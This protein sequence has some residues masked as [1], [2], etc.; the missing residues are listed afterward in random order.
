MRRRAPMLGW[1][2]ALTSLLLL[3]IV[4]AALWISI[5]RVV[6]APGHLEGGTLTLRAPLAGKVVAVFYEAGAMV[7]EGDALVRFD[8][9][10]AEAERRDLELRRQGQSER[11]DQL[12]AKR[13][14]LIR[15]IF[16]QERQAAEQ[17]WNR[18]RAA[19][20]RLV[21]RHRAAA[22]LADA[23]LAGS[24]ETEE[25]RLAVEAAAAEVARAA[26]ARDLLR[27]RQA[28]RLAELDQQRDGLLQSV[29]QLEGRLAQLEERMKMATLDAPRAGR[30]SGPRPEDLLGRRLDQ[31]EAVLAII[32]GPAERFVGTLGE[33]GRALVE[34]GMWVWLRLDAYP[35]L[36]HGSLPGRVERVGERSGPQGGCP[37]TVIFD[38][39]KAPGPLQEGMAGQARIVVK[40]KVSL[41]QLIL[42]RIAGRA[43]S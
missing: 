16:P 27:P 21:L 30:V 19:H 5:D 4:A 31:G 34:D 39:G 1:L 28:E 38:A 26:A 3:V 33:R 18:A 7:A 10:E 8:T 35:W 14:R 43:G 29:A 32:Y 25:S 9:R 23:G 17:D 24:L 36:I 41:G 22:R 42:E 40:G 2:I 6:T 13:Q 15:E 20:Q 11:S 37:V 12:L